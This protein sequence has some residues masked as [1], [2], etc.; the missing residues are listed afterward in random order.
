MKNTRR[1][2]LMLYL[3]I[4]IVFFGTIHLALKGLVSWFWLLVPAYFYWELTMRSK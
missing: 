2:E 1:A 4:I 3:W